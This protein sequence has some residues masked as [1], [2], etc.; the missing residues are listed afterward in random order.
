MSVG[1]LI[2]KDFSVTMKNN[3]LKLYDYDQK[4][5][6][7]FEQGSNRAFKVNVE[8]TDTKCLGAQG[9]E[10]DSELWNKRLGHLNFIKLG[11]LNSKKLIHGIPKIVKLEKTCEICMKDK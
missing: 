7:K 10:G 6:M 3:L 9:A 4:L 8:T 11:H 5:I 2:K 1:Q